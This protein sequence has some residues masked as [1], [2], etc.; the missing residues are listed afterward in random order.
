MRKAIDKKAWLIG[1]GIGSLAAAALLIRDGNMTGENI[2]MFELSEVAP[3]D[4]A[5]TLIGSPR[6]SASDCTKIC[7]APSQLHLATK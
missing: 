2:I 3:H 7:H 5:S 4:G 6:P 1:S